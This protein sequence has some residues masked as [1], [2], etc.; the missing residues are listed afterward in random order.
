[1]VRIRNLGNYPI[2]IPDFIRI[3]GVRTVAEVMTYIIDNCKVPEDFFWNR[4]FIL[5]NGK[6]P[7][8]E[9]TVS[10]GDMLDIIS[11]SEGG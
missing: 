8:M 9:D 3:E 11:Y 5:L 10:K 7:E 2:N 1:M 4:H 6:R